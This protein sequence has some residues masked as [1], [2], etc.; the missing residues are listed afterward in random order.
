MQGEDLAAVLREGAQRTATSP[1]RDETGL[2][3]FMLVEVSVPHR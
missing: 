1:Q 3:P 2:C